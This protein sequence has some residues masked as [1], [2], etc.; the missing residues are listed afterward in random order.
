MATDFLTA[1][2]GTL[3]EVITPDIVQADLAPASQPRPLSPGLEFVPLVVVADT[4]GREIPDNG[5]VRVARVLVADGH[6]VAGLDYLMTPGWPPGIT[7]RPPT[8]E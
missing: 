8:D 1:A 4:D 6:A 3:L 5:I 2:R 7:Y